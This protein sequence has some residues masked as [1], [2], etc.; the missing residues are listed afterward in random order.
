MGEAKRRREARAIDPVVYHHTSTLRTNLLWMSGVIAVEGD[1]EPVI[2][3]KLG[4]LKT[5]TK[6]RRAMTDFAPLAWFTTKI[7]CPRCLTD[8]PVFGIHN[9]TG[10]RIDIATE[11]G[12]MNLIALNRIAIGFIA[13][14]IPV[15]RWRDHYGYASA[16]GQKLNQTAREFGD[17]P[18]D[19]YVSEEPVDLLSATEIWSSASIVKPKYRRLPEY[20]PAMKDMVTRARSKDGIYIPPSWMTPE[21][22]TA[23]AKRL[24]V[25]A[26]MGG[27]LT[28]N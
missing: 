22:A 16:E 9:E 25:E 3:P 5:D 8:A 24:G 4:E 14:T 20:L 21:Q 26:R 12:S 19:W 6:M 11:P 27:N 15:V 17:D 1:D 13:S 2:H 28:D 23:L 10:E 18:D 7:D